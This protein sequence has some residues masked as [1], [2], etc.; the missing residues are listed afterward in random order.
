MTRRTAI[1]RF[2]SFP[3]SALFPLPLHT[4]VPLDPDTFTTQLVSTLNSVAHNTFPTISHA[5]RKPY[6][7]PATLQL[8]T[9]LHTL[10]ESEKRI[11]RLRVKRSALKDKKRWLLSKL[12]DDNQST[13]AADQWRTLRRLRSTYTPST[14]SVNNSDGTPVPRSQKSS[15]LADHLQNSVWAS[16]PLPPPDDDPIYPP[17]PLINQPFTMP[18]LLRALKRARSGRAPGPDRLPIEAFKFMPYVLKRSLLDYYNQCFQTA[19]AP[20]HWK[21]AKVVMLYKGNNKDSRSPS[22]YRPLSLANSIYK[23]Y[24]SM[25]QSRL[26]YFIDHRLQPQ[27]FGFRSGRSLSTPLF[28]FRRLTEL[29]E[30]HSSSLYLLFLDWSQAFDSIS[31][32]A[33]RAALLRYGIPIQT[34]DAVMALYHQ[35]QFFVQDQFSCSTT[36]SIG[37]GIRQGCPLSPYLFVIVLSAL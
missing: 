30:R 18:D 37:R 23:V 27:Q 1:G 14:Q 6:L 9:Q 36:R 31:H 35:G 3:P 10:P 21:L 13:S 32:P 33:L 17:I 25:L 24:A 8:S 20:T 22:S 15:I 26:S 5:A 12:H 19:T 2:S 4:T 16:A 34:V 7:S 11:A 28:I 29:F